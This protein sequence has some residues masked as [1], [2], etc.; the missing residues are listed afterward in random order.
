MKGSLLKKCRGFGKSHWK[1]KQEMTPEKQ[2][3]K[4]QTR[5][6][7]AN[8]IIPSHTMNALKFHIS[9]DMYYGN[10]SYGVS[11]FRLQNVIEFCIF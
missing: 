8:H 7:V 6:L 9:I 11:R 3:I 5:G 4:G 10:T 1:S 2:Q